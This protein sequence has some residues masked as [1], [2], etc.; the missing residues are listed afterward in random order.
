MSLDG[1][2][3]KDD[4]NI[5]FLSLAE[6][7][8]TDYGFADFLNNI[9]TIIWGRKTFDKV[10]SM[11]GEVPHK[12]KQIYLISRSRKGTH[13]HAVYHNNVVELVKKLKQE[14]GMHIYC[15]GGSEIIAELMKH[16]LVDRIIVSIIPYLLGGGIPLFRVGIPEKT[17]KF[18]Q[19]ITYS[20]SLV[21]LWYDVRETTQ[22]K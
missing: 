21:Q 16:S 19:C 22:D 7:P 12:N 6:T 9:D 4:G 2:I 17:L 18:I 20:S 15:D 8:E 13:E 14:E 3:A 1:Y 11:V 10:L 5:D